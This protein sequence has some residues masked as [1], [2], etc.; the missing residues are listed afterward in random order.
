[1]SP[2]DVRSLGKGAEASAQ[3][4]V[5]GAAIQDKDLRTARKAIPTSTHAVGTHPPSERRSLGRGAEA[6]KTGL[7]IFLGYNVILIFGVF[8][9]YRNSV[10][11]NKLACEPFKDNV[12]KTFVVCVFG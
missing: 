12:I 11:G 4:S 9:I 2:R 10:C 8:F 1:M 3:Q 6:S 5:P 7:R